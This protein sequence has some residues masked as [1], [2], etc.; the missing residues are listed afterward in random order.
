VVDEPKADENNRQP[1]PEINPNREQH[2]EQPRS[3]SQ[4]TKHVVMA[5]KRWPQRTFDYFQAR[6]GA[7]TALATV[8]I[9]ISTIVYVHY[10]GA[11]W[12]EMNRLN[13]FT[14]QAVDEARRAAD[15]AREQS[16]A[17]NKSIAIAADAL[18]LARKE[19]RAWAVPTVRGTYIFTPD[20]ETRVIVSLQ[21]YGK[22]PAQNIST[23]Y[24]VA[25]FQPPPERLPSRIHSEPPPQPFKRTRLHNGLVTP[26]DTL[27]LVV[28]ITVDAVASRRIDEGRGVLVLYGRVTYTDES[29]VRGES[30]FCRFY[31]HKSK[32]FALCPS[33]L[34]WAH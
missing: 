26:S 12:N 2:T 15:A 34:D 31:A 8:V 17:A 20:K 27:S 6:N 18:D 33:V 3:Y 29:T 16:V 1:P 21:N 30:G 10:S 28:D 25:I 13:K 19:R 7:I 5:L 9:A 4:R 23:E 24:T 11:Q 22:I 14:K 32:E